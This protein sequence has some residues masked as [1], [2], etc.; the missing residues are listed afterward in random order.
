MW[1][2]ARVDGEAED[3]LPAVEAAVR[4]VDGD[5][6]LVGVGTLESVV[7]GTIADSRFFSRLLAAFGLIALTLGAIGVYGVTSYVVSLEMGPIGVQMAL[8]AE[9]RRVLR[10]TTLQGLRPVILG[11]VLG[12]LAAAVGSR[13]LRGLL[14]GVTTTDPVTFVVVP[15]LLTAVA[16]VAVYLPA[17]RASRVDPMQVLRRE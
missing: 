12:L 7:G 3:V 10:A 5:V 14:F 4:G 2:V 6:A 9:P 1:L 16:A 17:R 8:G 11:I 13:V 15:L